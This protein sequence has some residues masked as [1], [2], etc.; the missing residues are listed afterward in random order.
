M[1]KIGIILQ[2]V[3]FNHMHFLHCIYLQHHIQYI[4][5][6]K[7]ITKWGGSVCNLKLDG[8]VFFFFSGNVNHSQN[9]VIKKYWQFVE[10][11]IHVVLSTFCPLSLASLTLRRSRITC[12]LWGV[13]KQAAEM[14]Q[15]EMRLTVYYMGTTQAAFSACR[16]QSH[17]RT[18]T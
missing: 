14:K 2:S 6:E 8:L 3:M 13:R 4:D 10:E 7:Q 15:E 11:Q 9:T 1:I 12:W 5:L 16:T 17:T 18:S